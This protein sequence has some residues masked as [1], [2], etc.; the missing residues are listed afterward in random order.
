[1][2]V[3]VFFRCLGAPAA[4]KNLLRPAWGPA[5]R[6]SFC[7]HIPHSLCVPVCVR[8]LLAA[9]IIN[10]QKKIWKNT[11]SYDDLRDRASTRATYAA[12]KAIKP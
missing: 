1:M 7:H 8:I 3:F 2:W 4:K 10:K 6:A 12:S 11:T 9:Q 5:R